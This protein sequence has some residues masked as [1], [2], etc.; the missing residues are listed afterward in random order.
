MTS[1]IIVGSR[2][3]RIEELLDDAAG[4]RAQAVDAT[5][6][7]A[8]G[9][10]LESCR[11]SSS[12]TSVA[13]IP[14]A[15]ANLKRQR[16]DSGV[17]IGRRGARPDADARGD[18]GGRQRVRGGA[19]DAGATS[20]ARSRACIGQRPSTEAGRTFGFV[21]AKGGV[22]TTT[23]AVNVAAALSRLERGP[24]T[25]LIDMHQAGG[26]AAV[27]TGA[28]P[29]FSILD[30]DR[31]THRL[32]QTYLSGLRRRIAPGLDLLASSDR[33]FATLVDPARVRA[34]LDFV[35]TCYRY[36]V[37]DLPRSDAAVLDALDK[38]TSVFIV[39]NQEFATVESGAR[40]ARCCG[41]GTDGRR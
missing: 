9:R 31:D 25:L 7:S 6:L 10:Q 15:L 29:K 39:A 26:D 11:T 34:V 35:A 27:F 20:S 22:G 23:V 3:R 1:V 36:T 32:D 16:P 4:L 14:P 12:W 19:A 37:L 8:F 17:V 13:P 38:V 41:N 28:D 21:G 2:D 5:A 33:A 30:A 18:A 24:R 40:M